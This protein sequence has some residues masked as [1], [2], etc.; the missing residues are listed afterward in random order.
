MMKEKGFSLVETMVAVLLLLLILIPL[1][2]LLTASSFSYNAAGNQTKALNAAREIIEELRLKSY[3][4]INNTSG[5]TPDGFKYSLSVVNKSTNLNFAIP[6]KEVS[7]TVYYPTGT[8]E[9]TVVLTT[10]FTP[11]NR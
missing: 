3:E 6:Y 1:L 8:G 9:K 5:V 10:V 2:N 11:R 4:Q 7:V